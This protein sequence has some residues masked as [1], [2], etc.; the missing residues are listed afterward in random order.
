MHEAVQLKGETL[1]SWVVVG[2]LSKD[3]AGRSIWQLRCT[4]C[5]RERQMGTHRVRDC[6]KRN[7]TPRCPTCIAKA[8]PNHKCGL[9]RQLGHTILDCPRR[10]EAKP[11]C[12]LCADLTHRVKGPRCRRCKL[13]YADEQPEIDYAPR[14]PSALARVMVDEERPTRARVRKSRVV[15]KRPS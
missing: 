2:L 11:V 13:R 9:C 7:V 4:G 12:P 15:N 14:Q 6:Q 3:P 1:G 5:G 8:N 10:S